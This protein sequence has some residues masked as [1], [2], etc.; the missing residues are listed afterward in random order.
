LTVQTYP[1]WILLQW[2]CLGWCFNCECWHKI[3]VLLVKQ[4]QGISSALTMT[5][6]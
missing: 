1:C 3:N 6:S 5:N 2:N 4:A